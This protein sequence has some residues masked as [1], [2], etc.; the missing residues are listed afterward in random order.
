MRITHSYLFFFQVIPVDGNSTVN[1]EPQ[2]S[3]LQIIP[4]VECSVK[5]SP[6][7]SL[8]GVIILQILIARELSNLREG[9]RGESGSLYATDSFIRV[10]RT[11]LVVGRFPDCL[12]EA[13]DAWTA[14][15]R[16]SE[17]DRPD[18]FPWEQFFLVFEFENGGVDLESFVFPSFDVC[19]SVVVQL[20]HGLHIAETLLGFEHRD[21]HIGNVLVKSTTQETLTFTIDGCRIA[22]RTHGVLVKIIDFTNSRLQRNGCTVYVNLGEDQALFQGP[23]DEYQFEVYRLMRRHNHDDWKAFQPKS[24]VFWLHYLLDKFLTRPV[25]APKS[26]KAKSAS[27][28]LR[29]R[30]RKALQRLK[31]EVLRF[32]SCADLALEGDLEK[33]VLGLNPFHE[34]LIII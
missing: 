31:D 23:D 29:G 14:G 8:N 19:Q 15:E 22:F 1:G 10:I 34:H 11:R 3:L 17:N 24:N 13:W 7:H 12:L 32:Q 28:Q 21:L 18:F 6:H 4:E 26:A 33:G 20:V 27:V 2:K 30:D 25:F 16:E 5:C 9:M